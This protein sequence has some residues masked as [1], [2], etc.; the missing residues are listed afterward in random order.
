MTKKIALE[1]ANDTK[2]KLTELTPPPCPRALLFWPGLANIWLSQPLDRIQIWKKPIETEA[3]SQNV[4]DCTFFSF[5]LLALHAN[6]LCLSSWPTNV[7]L[8]M[9]AGWKKAN[10]RCAA[11]RT[12]QQLEKNPSHENLFESVCIYFDLT[13]TCK[14]PVAIAQAHVKICC[15][16]YIALFQLARFL[17]KCH[18]LGTHRIRG[19]ATPNQQIWSLSTPNLGSNQKKVPKDA[20]RWPYWTLDGWICTTWMLLRPATIQTSSPRSNCVKLCCT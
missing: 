12:S 11:E 16:L 18:L 5:S 2:Q 19:E 3:A 15:K 9:E 17:W 13:Q 20:N 10:H 4:V 1:I 7:L 14:Q 8:W 6:V